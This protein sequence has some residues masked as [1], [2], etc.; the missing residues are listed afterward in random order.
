MGPREKAVMVR[1]PGGLA[2][3][4]LGEPRGEFEPH[5]LERARLVV[6]R[7]AADFAGLSALLEGG[8]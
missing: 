8:S 1:A 6:R 5:A 3:G 2:R 7:E 4:V